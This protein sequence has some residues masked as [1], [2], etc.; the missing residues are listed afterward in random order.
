[1]KETNKHIEQEAPVLFGLKREHNLEVPTGY[2]D[3]LPN[4]LEKIV[5][6]DS[7]TTPIIP[8]KSYWVYA[9]AI[10][11]LFIAGVF[12]YSPTQKPSEELLAYNETFN[13]LTAENFEDLLILE[14]DEFLSENID[15][16]DTEEL[17]F[18]ASEL[19]EPLLEMEITEQDFENYFESEIEEY[20]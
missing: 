15:F 3:K 20:Y 6:E 8:L 17:Q 1:M 7:K 13:N 14:Q 16:D 9:S 5:E 19:Q 11:A 2:F 10:A 4:Q 12:L 18:W